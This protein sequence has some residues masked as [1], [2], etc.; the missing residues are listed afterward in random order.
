MKEW[1]RKSILCL[2]LSVLLVKGLTADDGKDEQ[3]RLST[4]SAST[5]QG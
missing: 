2:L 4:S 1:T 5:Q 3:P